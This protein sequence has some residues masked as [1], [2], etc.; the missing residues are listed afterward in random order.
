[1][2]LVAGAEIKVAFRYVYQGQECENVQSYIASGLTTTGLT[3]S[4]WLEGLWNDYKGRLR[5]AAPANPDVGHFVSLFGEE[6]GG[7]LNFA[8][9]PIPT[10]EQLGTRGTSSDTT[11]MNSFTA[12]GFRQTVAT[13]LTRPGQKRFPWLVE[14]DVVGNQFVGGVNSLWVDVA[15]AF[16]NPSVLGV[17]A[18]DAAP[19]PIVVHEPGSRDPVRHEQAVSGFVFRDTPT[20]QV[21]RKIGRGV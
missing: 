16:C 6:H 17:P 20:S 12:W 3:M 13:R 15:T 21:S 19:I 9:F 4:A 14:S 10:G 18:L 5:A 7:G 11:W 2:S 1:M 8:E